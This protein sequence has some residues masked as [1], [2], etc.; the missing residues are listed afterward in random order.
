MNPLKMNI[1]NLYFSTILVNF[2]H[3][4]HWAFCVLGLHVTNHNRHNLTIKQVINK[5]SHGHPSLNTLYVIKHHARILQ[6]IFRLHSPDKIKYEHSSINI[7]LEQIN[8]LPSLLTMKTIVLNVFVT[9]KCFQF[10]DT[11]NEDQIIGMMFQWSN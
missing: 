2:H 9:K 4:I 8:L 7:H 3:K 5:T 10:E 6:I 1:P 11:V